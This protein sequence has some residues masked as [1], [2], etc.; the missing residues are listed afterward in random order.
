[1]CLRLY[2]CMQVNGINGGF[3]LFFRVYARA[4]SC[5]QLSLRRL[6]Y[7]L[8]HIFTSDRKN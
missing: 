4:L 1:M 2:L 3:Y 8:L 5:A 7:N 6:G